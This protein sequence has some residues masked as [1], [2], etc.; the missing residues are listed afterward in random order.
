MVILYSKRI[1]SLNTTFGGY[2]INTDPT[3]MIYEF[4]NLFGYDRREH[5]FK[6][7]M[8]GDHIL[9]ASASVIF[10]PKK[11]S[12][13]VNII[14]KV[15]GKIVKD[16]EVKTGSMDYSNYD[17]DLVM[18]LHLNR[19]DKVEIFCSSSQEGYLNTKEGKSTLSVV[20]LLK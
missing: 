18:T 13:S 17:C 8:E 6:S 7:T 10:K 16:K 9:Q 4:G 12:D 1:T 20:R 15:N 19:M 2:I 3:K 11:T 5:I 14:I